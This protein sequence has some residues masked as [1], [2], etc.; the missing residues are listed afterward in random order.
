[1]GA[2]SP[3]IES[4]GVRIGRSMPTESRAPETYPYTFSAATVK[5]R[6]PIRR[7]CLGRLRLFQGVRALSASTQLVHPK[8]WRLEMPFVKELRWPSAPQEVPILKRT[9]AE[10]SRDA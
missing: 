6:A 5:S 2:I 1:M 3:Y 10:M 8:P 4:G 7:S 9:S